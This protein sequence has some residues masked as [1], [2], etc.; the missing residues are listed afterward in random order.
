M[1]EK[2]NLYQKIMKLSEAAVLKKDGKVLDRNDRPLYDIRTEEGI[3][4]F[5]RPKLRELGLHIIVVD[6]NVCYS[7]PTSIKVVTKCVIVDVETGD[8]QQFSGVGSGIDKGDKDSG[9]AFTYAFRNGIQKLLML[10]SGEDSDTTSS[11]QNIADLAD[12][13]AE[14]LKQLYEA[15]AFAVIASSG[16]DAGKRPTKSMMEVRYSEKQKTL[17][18]LPQTVEAYTEQIGKMRAALSALKEQA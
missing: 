11:Q 15:G 2:M 8:Q 5:F 9:K 7:S 4:S 3:L 18:N 16:P 12:E 14:L 10:V 6:I 13:M 17:G 1:E